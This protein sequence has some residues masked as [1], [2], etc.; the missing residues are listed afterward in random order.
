MQALTERGVCKPGDIDYVSQPRG[1]I[2]HVP[3]P[4]GPSSAVMELAG[5][6][7]LTSL[8]ARK[9][10][11]LRVLYSFVMLRTCAT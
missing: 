10:R 3:E 6:S 11:P 5:T 2:T 4:E 9:G 7:R 8:T 1:Q